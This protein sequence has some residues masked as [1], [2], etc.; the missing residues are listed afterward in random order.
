[1]K[2]ICMVFILVTS[3]L[4]VTANQDVDTMRMPRSLVYGAGSTDSREISFLEQQNFP[5]IYCT[6]H[7]VGS[8]GATGLLVQLWNGQSWEDSM[9]WEYIYQ[10]GRIS[11]MIMT[12]YEPGQT[13]QSR[14]VVTYDASENIIET[15]MQ[16]FDG[17]NWIP[18]E[19]EFY[20]YG[21]D[22]LEQWTSYEDYGGDEWTEEEQSVM[23]YTG[24]YLASIVWMWY[25]DGISA[26]VDEYRKFFE[27]MGGYP[28]TSLGQY[29]NQT[30]EDDLHETFTFDA[31]GNIE[32]EVEQLW[33]GVEWQ[34]SQRYTYSYDR[35]WHT[36]M[37]TEDWNGTA[38]ENSEQE[39]IT[40]L[41]NG[42]PGVVLAEVWQGDEW[43]NSWQY[44][45]SYGPVGSGHPVIAAEG[46]VTNYPN[47]FGLGAS[48][49]S[50]TTIE[51]SLIADSPVSIE[52]FDA[53]GRLVSTLANQHYPAGTHQVLWDGTAADGTRCSSGIY[54]YKIKSAVMECARKMLLIL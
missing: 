14:V 51:F 21:V 6:V 42:L 15:E 41:P 34:N 17:T 44:T 49:S 10:N 19:Q 20:T 31:N 29:W 12:Q 13:N 47:P 11:E 23:S 4:L 9:T 48:R 54:F 46:W 1:M 18:V 25:N 39:T 24:G 37:L 50:T 5:W 28:A 8:M 53:K 7:T 27:Y 52:V 30:W 32:E 16:A 43:Q 33:S 40:A 45:F 36:N 22:G 35:Q 38:W 2:R 3:L 26:W